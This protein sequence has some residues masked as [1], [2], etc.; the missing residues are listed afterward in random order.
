MIGG[1]YISAEH[2]ISRERRGEFTYTLPP[3]AINF[4][5]YYNN[6]IRFVRTI[7]SPP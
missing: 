1:Y 3:I 4:G 2:D 6:R 5:S 7:F